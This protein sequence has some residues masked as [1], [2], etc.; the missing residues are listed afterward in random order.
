MAG[1]TFIVVSDPIGQFFHNLKTIQP[2][3]ASIGSPD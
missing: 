1:V 3:I 2:R